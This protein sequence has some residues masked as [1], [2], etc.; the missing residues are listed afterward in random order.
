MRREICR[1]KTKMESRPPERCA[2]EGPGKLRPVGATPVKAVMKQRNRRMQF[3]HD[4]F[5]IAGSGFPHGCSGDLEVGRG[6]SVF[7]ELLIIEAAPNKMTIVF[8]KDQ[9]GVGSALIDLFAEGCLHFL[10]R[11]VRESHQA[12]AVERHPLRFAMLQEGRQW[13]RALSNRGCLE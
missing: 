3:A 10:E 11:N 4:P 8:G 12:V 7:V 5:I 2:C 6:I 13:N 1:E 9:L